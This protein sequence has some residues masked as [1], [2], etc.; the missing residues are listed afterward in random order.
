MHP[1]QYK[2]I[3]HCNATVDQHWQHNPILR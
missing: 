1:K 3:A 2:Y